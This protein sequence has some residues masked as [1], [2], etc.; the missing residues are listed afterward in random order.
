[1]RGAPVDAGGWRIAYA[2]G[3]QY[4]GEVRGGAPHGRGVMKFRSGDV[5]DGEWRAGRR[6][7]AGRCVFADGGTFD[8]E[9]E[10]DHISLTG[11]GTLDLG[12]G[13][14]HTFV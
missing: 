14:Q 2:D 9:W 10:D 4:V 5:Y 12:H 8:G 7:G 3:A 6:A 1:M 11:R 13:A